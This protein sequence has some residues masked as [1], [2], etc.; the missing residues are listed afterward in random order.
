MVSWMNF[1]IVLERKVKEIESIIKGYL[2]EESG[3]AR[4]EEGWKFDITI[5]A[6]C[7]AALTLPG[8]EAVALDAG[9]YAFEVRT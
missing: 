7:T 3:W 8:E 4:T 1:D 5:P 2:P 6:N 9:T